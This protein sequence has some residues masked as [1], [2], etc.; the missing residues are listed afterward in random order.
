V[1]IFRKLTALYGPHLLCDSC[2]LEILDVQTGVVLFV[3]RWTKNHA[4]E[5]GLIIHKNCCDTKRVVRS[6]ELEEFLQLRKLTWPLP[7]DEVY[8]GTPDF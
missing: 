4:P 8:D 2:H 3:N 1:L 7:E 6:M 5:M